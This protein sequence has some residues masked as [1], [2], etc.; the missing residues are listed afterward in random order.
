MNTLE[1]DLDLILRGIP[2]SVVTFEVN[3]LSVIALLPMSVIY[4]LQE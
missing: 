3:F 1:I 4:H 2:F